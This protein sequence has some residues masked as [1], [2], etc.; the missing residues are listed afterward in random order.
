MSS[1]ARLCRLSR[2]HLLVCP[3]A[4]SMHARCCCSDAC[5]CASAQHGW[6]APFLLRRYLLVYP[7]GCD[8]ANH[9]SLF[10]CVADYDK[11][12][13]GWSHFAQVRF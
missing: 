13:P 11:L 12:L 2:R 10:L 6:V 5:A 1:A 8:V 7:H 4:C 9:L 3:H